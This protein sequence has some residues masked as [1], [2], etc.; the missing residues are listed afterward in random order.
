MAHFHEAQLFTKHLQCGL[1]LAKIC[2][3]QVCLAARLSL[4]FAIELEKL[5]G[6]SAAFEECLEG[7]KLCVQLHVQFQVL[8]LKA[9]DSLYLCCEQIPILLKLH[10][11][12]PNF[13]AFDLK[14]LAKF[15]KLSAQTIDLNML[16][17]LELLSQDT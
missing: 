4:L 1:F 3:A 7:S 6:I 8:K 9:I 15:F 11:L 12:E 10:A 2:V 13:V 16:A 14:R 17:M 5:A